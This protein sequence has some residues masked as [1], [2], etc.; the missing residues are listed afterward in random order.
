MQCEEGSQKAVAQDRRSLERRRVEAL[1]G[2][3]VEA[4]APLAGEPGQELVVVGRLQHVGLEEV[5]VE[6]LR[7]AVARG[8][9]EDPRRVLAAA[10]TPSVRLALPA[11]D[12]APDEPLVSSESLSSRGGRLASG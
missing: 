8:E 1:E 2:E 12:C 10:P 6:P 9:L 3:H 7:L 4:V 5:V 11:A